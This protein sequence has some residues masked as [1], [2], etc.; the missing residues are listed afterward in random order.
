MDNELF[1]RVLRETL[2]ELRER[3]TIGTL[4]EKTLHAVLKKYFEPEESGR[5][6]KLGSFWADVCGEDGIFEIQTRSLYKL[7]EKLKYFLAVCP[8]TVVYPIPAKRSLMWIN[9]ETGEETPGGNVSKKGKPA[10]AFREL[11]GI[12]QFLGHKNLSVCIVMV[13]VC[14]YKLLNGFGEKKKIR[15][16]RYDRIPT[17]LSREIYLNVPE[18]Y[19]LLCPENLPEEFSSDD[20][21]KASKLK[22]KDAR[23]A[24][25]ILCS[26][27]ASEYIGLSGR[28]K[29]YRFKSD[30]SS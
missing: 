23:S 29:L 10:D 5:E 11:Y 14:D 1:E 13:D 8:V 17:A 27:G 21:A 4:G 25:N 30:F 12:K 24:V 22:L 15:A 20:F 2:S 9:P 18:D 6:V 19:L 16:E 3:N 7:S 26:V 28:K